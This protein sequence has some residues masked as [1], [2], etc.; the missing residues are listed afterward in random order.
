MVLSTGLA[1]G[2]HHVFSGGYLGYHGDLPPNAL[3]GG[4]W[5]GA[6]AGGPC[7]GVP[8]LRADSLRSNGG[9]TGTQGAP[10]QAPVVGAST[11]QHGAGAGHYVH[12]LAVAPRRAPHGARYSMDRLTGP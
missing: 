10:A 11:V 6:D 2:D 9:R 1:A 7:A 3:A 4:T 12:A 8:V 5:R